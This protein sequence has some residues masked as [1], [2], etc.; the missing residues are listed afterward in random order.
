[1]FIALGADMDS[2]GRPRKQAGELATF[3][4]GIAKPLMAKG[5]LFITN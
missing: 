5:V 1:L 2:S 3:P 4:R